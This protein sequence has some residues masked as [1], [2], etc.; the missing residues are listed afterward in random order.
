MHHLK[1]CLEGS[2]FNAVTVLVNAGAGTLSK[3]V[4]FLFVFCN[5]DHGPIQRAVAN[6]IM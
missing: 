4:N 2:I 6:H 5:T 1:Q 3:L